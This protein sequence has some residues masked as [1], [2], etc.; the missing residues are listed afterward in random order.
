MY[1]RVFQ[2][3]DVGLTESVGDAGD[4]FELWYR[5][6]TPFT[7]FALQ[8]CSSQV[9]NTHRHRPVPDP[10]GGAP[11]PYFWQSQF[12]FLH[13]IQCRKNILKCNLD[14]IVAEIRGVLEVN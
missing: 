6:Q 5:K 10:G 8:A 7:T 1:I 9:C 11:P 13:F 12:Y 4:T 3:T 14:F 2:T